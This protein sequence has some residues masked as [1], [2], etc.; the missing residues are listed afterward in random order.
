MLCQQHRNTHVEQHTYD[1]VRNGDK[2]AGSDS[3]VY[4]QFL[5]GQWHQGAEDGSEH[6]YGKQADG[7]RISDRSR[8]SIADKI[9]N[10]D[11]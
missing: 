10:I 4:F 9:V 6:D 3:G 2:G 8:P 7:H 5:Q 1:V 11:Q